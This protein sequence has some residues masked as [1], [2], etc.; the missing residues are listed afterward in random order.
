MKIDTIIET[1]LNNH[2]LP[3]DM[4]AEALTYPIS[5][6]LGKGVSYQDTMKIMEQAE[7]SLSRERAHQVSFGIKTGNVN[8]KAA[9]K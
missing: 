8:F 7:I 6:Y 2:C 3:V 9:K 5:E 1:A 4:A